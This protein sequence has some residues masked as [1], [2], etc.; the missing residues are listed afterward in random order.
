[1][2]ETTKRIDALTRWI[3]DQVQDPNFHELT[4]RRIAWAVIEGLFPRAKLD[5]C[6]RSLRKKKDCRNRGG[7][8]MNS[9]KNSF[10]ECDLDW[11][12]KPMKKLS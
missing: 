11:K 10:R 7:Y 2:D 4:C 9:I 8:F 12:G 6:L 5:G 3:L 1:M